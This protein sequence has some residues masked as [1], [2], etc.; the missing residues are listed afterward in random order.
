MKIVIFSKAWDKK[1]S[2]NESKFIESLMMYQDFKILRPHFGRFMRLNDDFRGIRKNWISTIC[3]SHQGRAKNRPFLMIFFIFMIKNP[4]MFNLRVVILI[5]YPQA[6]FYQNLR[7][8][9]GSASSN[10]PFFS[11]RQYIQKVTK[12][13]SFFPWRSPSS[14]YYPPNVV[15]SPK[16]PL[17]SKVGFFVGKGRTPGER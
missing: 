15:K 8:F 7:D 9:P 12:K 10:A 11:K 5:Q 14:T 1:W 16:K 4:K 6:S 13:L 17:I 2:K 3:F